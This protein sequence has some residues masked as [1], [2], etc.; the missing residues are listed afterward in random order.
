MKLEKNGDGKSGGSEFGWTMKLKREFELILLAI[1]NEEGYD[2]RKKPGWPLPPSSTFYS[3]VLA[4]TSKMR[5]M[6]VLLIPN[7]EM[8]EKS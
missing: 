6:V 8:K 4:V 5:G 7:R 2:A 3:I 1:W